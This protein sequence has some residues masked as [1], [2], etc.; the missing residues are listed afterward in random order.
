MAWEDSRLLST[1]EGKLEGSIEES[2]YLTWDFYV[3]FETGLNIAQ[4][5]L[6]VP[7]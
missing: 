3:F 7:V 6:E 2:W 5:A 1:F 4:V